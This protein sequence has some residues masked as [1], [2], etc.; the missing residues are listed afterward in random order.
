MPKNFRSSRNVMR[1]QSRDKKKVKHGKYLGRIK[2]QRKKF[3]TGKEKIDKYQKKIELETEE[4]LEITQLEKKLKLSGSS[5]PASF[6]DEGLGFI[7]DY[8]TDL[9]QDVCSDSNNESESE[10][11]VCSLS[12]VESE[13]TLREEEKPIIQIEKA[14]CEIRYSECSTFPIPSS[15][16]TVDNTLTR[17]MTGLVNRLSKS[18]LSYTTGQMLQL[19]RDNSAHDMN[20]EISCVLSRACFQEVLV[21]ERLSIECM[22][23]L[24]ITQGKA[25]TGIQLG[26]Y[27]IS[28]CVKKFDSCYK[29]ENEP[30]KLCHNLIR[31]LSYLY[32]FKVLTSV[33]IYDIVRKL[34]CECSTMDIELLL[35][36]LKT[37]GL[38]IRKEDPS[39]MK[40]I[41][42]EIQGKRKII[43][44]QN[45]DSRVVW[46]L[47]TINAIKSNNHRKIPNYDPSKLEEYCKLL[48]AAGEM[49]VTPLNLRYEDVLKLD[50]R[51]MSR[52][53]GPGGKEISFET[54]NGSRSKETA[55]FSKLMQQQRMN[56]DIRR[57]IFT[58]LMTSSDYMEAVQN[59][60][61]LDLTKIQRREIA[62]IIVECCI[63]E[64][65][66]NLYYA[67]LS[68]YLCNSARD[69]QVTFQYTLWDKIKNLREM[70]SLQTTNFIK[71]ILH[72][73][74]S[75]SL[76]ISI[77][78]VISFT[79]IDKITIKFLKKILS[80][81]IFDL[82]EET[83]IN[84]FQGLKG[85]DHLQNFRYSV[86]LFLKHL[87][88]SEDPVK[89]RRV[90]IVQNAMGMSYLIKI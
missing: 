26:A 55:K 25:I 39:S 24:A 32:S 1:K 51:G 84:I 40:D 44:K 31:C 62:K 52:L 21:Q 35:I 76:S 63:Q 73:V 43:E 8:K 16:Q 10:D 23:L 49:E 89:N 77:L 79:E 86:S 90:S 3:I 20:E 28:K 75:K 41:I 11:P 68:Q 59:L 57:K 66:F 58:V 12:E 64:N 60:L 53:L 50:E 78:K 33:L 42:M 87:M 2:P 30:S 18:N 88:K 15:N 36:I 37:V 27:F 83:I 4:N 38:D 82:S 71:L 29:N 61:K 17:R 5:L 74:Q 69:N 46:M 56:T 85:K 22:L 54:R 48:K 9:K 14:H 80:L 6:Y 19:Y 72:L 47:D 13:A 70:S 7:L 45:D 81:I 34:V 65:P 67:Y